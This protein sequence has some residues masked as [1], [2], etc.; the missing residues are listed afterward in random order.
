MKV[1][2]KVTKTRAV[3]IADDRDGLTNITT[4]LNW[5]TYAI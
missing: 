4:L 1:G 3:L 5:V 2:E